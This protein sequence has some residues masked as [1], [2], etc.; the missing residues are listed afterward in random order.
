[1]LSTTK[2]TPIKASLAFVKAAPADLYTFAGS[3][4][5]G[6]NGNAA[7]SNP[8]VDMP[9]FK[10]AIDT[11]GTLNVAA[12]DGGKKV[13]TQRDHQG[14]GLIKI[15][16]QLVHYVEGACKD[17]PTIF[18]SSGFQAL[19]KVRTA[20]PPLSQSIRKITE[21]PNSGVL[22][23]WL[24][25]VAGALSY[26]F[27]WAPVATGSSATAAPAWTSSLVASTQPP[28]PVSNL[29]PGTVY[30]FEV[31]VLSKTGWSDWGGNATRMA[32]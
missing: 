20:I 7:Y 28:V 11:F 21:G 31:R 5:T 30:Q 15:L 10:T 14:K 18:S 3:V 32:I 27:R 16:R 13:L 8:T 25:S 17:D 12:L 23:L 9:T 6:M 2:V 19:S 24:L 29:I 1:M 26:E 4:Y 22:L